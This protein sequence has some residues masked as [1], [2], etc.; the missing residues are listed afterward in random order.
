[1]HVYNEC[2][3]FVN[4]IAHRIL[5]H[6]SKKVELM[7]SSQNVYSAVHWLQDIREMLL[8]PSEKCK[9]T[10]PEINLFAHFTVLWCS[11]LAIPRWLP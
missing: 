9:L 6:C 8:L 7:A 2:M 1:M 11:G 4:N 3:N 5:L 10:V